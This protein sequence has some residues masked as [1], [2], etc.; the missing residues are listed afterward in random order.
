[1]GYVARDTSTRKAKLWNGSVWSAG[2]NDRHYYI[3]STLFENRVLAETSASFN[4]KLP[5]DYVRIATQ[6]Y[7]IGQSVTSKYYG[8][9]T[10]P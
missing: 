3:S 5:T 7:S 9:H 1:M 10:Y 8:L 6:G 4:Y 2:Q